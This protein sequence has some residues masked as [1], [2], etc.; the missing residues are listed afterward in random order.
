MTGFS[1]DACGSHSSGGEDSRV[2][3]VKACSLIVAK[4]LKDHSAFKV[5]DGGLGLLD[6]DITEDKI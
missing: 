3:G 6:L 5:K 1:S 2:L 4:F